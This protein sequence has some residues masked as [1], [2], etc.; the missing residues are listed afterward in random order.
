MIVKN[1]EK[2]LPRLLGSIKGLADEIIVVDTGSEDNTVEIAKSF[3]AKVYF[4]EWCDDF[5]AARNESLRHATCD[6]ILWLDGDDE[7]KKEEHIKIKNALSK[8][9]G[10]AFY[11]KIRSITDKGD[12]ECI[13]MRMFPRRE[14]IRFEGSVHEQVYPSIERA[15][16]PMSLCDAL[17]IHHGYKESS[18]SDNKLKRNLE[19]LKKDLAREPDNVLTLFFLGRTLR[20]LNQLEDSAFYYDR[21][22]EKGKDDS[23]LKTTDLYQITLFERAGIFASNGR[24]KEAIDLLENNRNVGSKGSNNII[25]F[26]LGELYYK[27]KEYEKAYK[28]L[29]RIKDVSFKEELVPIDLKL[30]KNNLY[31]YLGVSS[32]FVKDYNT[33]KKYIGISIEYDPQNP[34]NYHYLILCEEKQGNI[35]KAIDI[36]SEALERFHNN[37]SFIKKR[38]LLRLENGYL[39]DID[40]DL[41]FFE[42]ETQDVEILCGLLLL[43]SMKLSIDGITKYYSAIQRALFLPVMPF[44]EGYMEVKNR[45]NDLNEKKALSLMERVIDTFLNLQNQNEIT[46]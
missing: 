5:S 7:L 35:K 44:P 29:Y 28:Y 26:T 37:I 30:I 22:I 10:Y 3:G 43:S 19:I 20:G 27:S 9:R 21:I 16:I 38:F 41:P 42:H 13:Q 14:D 33:A 36:C 23:R 46:L 4:F 11:L 32:L 45:L 39:Y 6:Y 24:L 2:N 25:D 12:T 34:E 18:D 15:K 17:I 8:N 1:E 31:H 40:K